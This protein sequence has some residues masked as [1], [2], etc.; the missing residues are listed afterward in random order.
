[1]KLPIN[2]ELCKF[3]SQK[4]PGSCHNLWMFI[5]R[6]DKMTTG[7]TTFKTERKPQFFNLN[8]PPSIILQVMCSLVCELD[9]KYCLEAK[10]QRRFHIWK[11]GGPQKGAT[12]V[13]EQTPQ[14]GWIKAHMRLVC[15]QAEADSCPSGIEYKAFSSAGD[16]IWKSASWEQSHLNC[17]MVLQLHNLIVVMFHPKVSVLGGS[18]HIKFVSH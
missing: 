15:E 12:S 18:V 16:V 5:P 17:C 4:F 1:M 10:G 14:I 6:A 2:G 11:A 13:A 3:C 8:F 9:Q 7:L